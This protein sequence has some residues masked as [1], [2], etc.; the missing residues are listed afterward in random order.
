VTSA[1]HQF[2][3]E[4]GIR[5][6][7]GR[8][9]LAIDE[10]LRNAGITSHIWA[11]EV[12]SDLRDRAG[13]FESADIAPDDL[14]MY[15]FAVGHDMAD[16][17]VARSERLIIDYHNITPRRFFEAWDAGLVHAVDWG[18][19]QLPSMARR[20]DLS[21]ADS[22]FN[23]GE[24]IE[25]GFRNV[26][27]VP[28]LLDQSEFQYDSSA[29][30][31]RSE[32]G[33]SWLFVGRIVPNK[34]QHDLIKAFAAYRHVY[35][36]EATLAIVGSV[37]S[38]RYNE[39]LIGMIKDLNLGASVTLTGSVSPAQLDAHY[40]DADVLV[41]LSEHEGFCVPLLEAMNHQ[42]PIVAYAAG[43]VPETLGSAGI[44]LNDKS[45]AAVAAAVRRISE[46]GELRQ[47][48]VRRTRDRLDHFGIQ[49]SQRKLLDAIS[50]LLGDS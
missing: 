3:P 11:G 7:V 23:A 46:D 42:L 18:I 1:V 39:A 6:A 17:L 28:I 36:A 21:L 43:A 38:Q 20:C 31:E 12:H 29:P 19:R 45:P 32:A 44:L 9:T 33:R 2:V 13:H 10:T 30:V 40:R 22:A 41:C 15:Q 5:D 35:D 8:H 37:S 47:Q 34:A 26:H 49:R 4:L 16:W 50:P 14:L 27:V 24:L 48:L 25:L